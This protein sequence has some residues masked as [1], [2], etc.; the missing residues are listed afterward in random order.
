MLNKAGVKEA[1]AADGSWH[2]RD[3]IIC[4][5]RGGIV[6]DGTLI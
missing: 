5:P 4:V 2:I 6:P 1:D 3:G